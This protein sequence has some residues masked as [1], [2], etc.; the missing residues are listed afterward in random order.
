M[1]LQSR[2]YVVL[3]VD[4]TSLIS[5]QGQCVTAIRFSYSDVTFFLP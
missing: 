1:E 5:L 4:A 3:K 2:A